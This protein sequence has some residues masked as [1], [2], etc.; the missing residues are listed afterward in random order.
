[1]KSVITEYAGS[2]VAVLGTIGFFV[3]ISDMLIGKSGLVAALIT[4]VLGGI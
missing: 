1:M 3:I 4:A 2:V